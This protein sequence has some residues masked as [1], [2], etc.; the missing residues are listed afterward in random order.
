M[1]NFLLLAIIGILARIA[2]PIAAAVVMNG[3]HIL[4]GLH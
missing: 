2:L 3:H 1:L 4:G